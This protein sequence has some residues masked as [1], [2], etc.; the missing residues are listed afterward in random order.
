[1]CYL[2]QLLKERKPSRSRPWSTE[3]ISP[4]LQEVE[5]DLERK[6]MSGHLLLLPALL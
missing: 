4:L 5:D 1:M 3:F 2:I 6:G